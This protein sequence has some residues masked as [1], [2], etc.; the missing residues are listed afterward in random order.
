[1]SNHWLSVFGAC[2]VAVTIWKLLGWV[3]WMQQQV[4]VSA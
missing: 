1:M 2:R 4:G 3:M